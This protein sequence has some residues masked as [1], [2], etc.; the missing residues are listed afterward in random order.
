MKSNSTCETLEE[1]LAVI[2]MEFGSLFLCIVVASLFVG[3]I[4]RS[5]GSELATVSISFR[6]DNEQPI[7]IQ[8]EPW[9]GLYMLKKGEEIQFIGEGEKKSPNFGVD[10]NGHTRILSLW[11][12]EYY[13]VVDGKR[14]HWQKYYLDPR[15]CPNCL[16]SLKI[17]DAY[18]VAGEICACDKSAAS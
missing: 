17:E 7:L 6:N 16:R 8:V 18:D 5:K 12:D 3:F 11:T 1:E 10:E 15:L 13:V 9:A 2:S 4:L 14:V